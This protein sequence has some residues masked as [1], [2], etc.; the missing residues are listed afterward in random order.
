MIETAES[1]EGDMKRN[2]VLSVIL[3]VF[4]ASVP[5]A[6]I[7]NGASAAT[8]V[9]LSPA[10][11][12]DQSLTIESTFQL[13]VHVDAISNLWAWRI[14]LAWNSSVL[15]MSGAPVEGSFLKASYSTIFLPATPNNT[16]GVL[17]EQACTIFGAGGVSGSGD[18][19]TLTFKVVGY[20]SSNVDMNSTMME[21]GSSG[22]H[23][24][25]PCSTVGAT[26]NL[27][28]PSP[29]PPPPPP[30]SGS[31]GPTASF[32]PTNGTFFQREKP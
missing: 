31:H 10:V 28:N 9:S 27:Q 12:S 23:V 26:F 4:V 29:P 6:L 18:L 14:S 30:S 24:Q 22:N 32:A 15:E 19:A 1:G 3:I 21:Y 5:F 20:G 17:E 16:N 11:V 25:I 2:H 13:K 7:I 8:V